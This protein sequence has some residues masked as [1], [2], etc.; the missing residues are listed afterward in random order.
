MQLQPA[1]PAPSLVSSQSICPLLRLPWASPC[2]WYIFFSILVSV[3]SLLE[4]KKKKKKSISQPTPSLPGKLFYCS[5]LSSSVLFFGKPPPAPPSS[6]ESPRYISTVGPAIG[7]MTVSS[8]PGPRP[9]DL[10]AISVP[11]TCLSLCHRVL[12]CICYAIFLQN[13]RSSW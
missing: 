5:R 4:G 6:P 1:C 13:K 7:I 9:G 11:H 8:I 2:L 3:S 10:L 12:L